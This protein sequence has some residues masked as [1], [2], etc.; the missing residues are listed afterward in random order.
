MKLAG[1]FVLVSIVLFAAT[2]VLSIKAPVV[3]SNQ[4]MLNA[5]GAFNNINEQRAIVIKLPHKDIIPE[6]Y[7]IYLKVNI[8]KA[9]KEEGIESGGEKFYRRLDEYL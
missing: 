8:S 1:L 3:H 7:T 4:K 5:A 9:K 2:L 6:D